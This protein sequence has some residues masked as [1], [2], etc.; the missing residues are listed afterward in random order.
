MA[1]AIHQDARPSRGRQP[2]A[3][4]NIGTAIAARAAPD[5]YTLFCS[6]A[7]PLALNQHL[8]KRMPFDVARDFDP[9]TLIGLSP[10]LIAANTKIGVKTLPELIARAKAE[11]GKVS[12]AT[13]GTKNV[14]QS[15]RRAAEVP[16][17]H[18]DAAGAVSNLATG[19]DGHHDRNSGFHDRRHS[20]PAAAG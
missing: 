20:G 18:P 14:P 7:A 17:R 12:F 3:G 15:H 5:G 4:G 8:F 6:Q 13:S 11:P 16:C 19:R 1:N 2:G 10:M 9:I